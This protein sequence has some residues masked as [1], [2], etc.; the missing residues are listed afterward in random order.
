MRFSGLKLNIAVTVI[1]LLLTS[2]VLGNFVTVMF[3]KKSLVSSE[4][5]QA[6]SLSLIMGG[7][8]SGK[9]VSNGGLISKDL[10]RFINNSDNLISSVFF[11]GKK[12]VYIPENS[13]D[14]YMEQFVRNAG[15]LGEEQIKLDG[16]IWGLFSSQAPT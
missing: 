14:N 10:R 12:M 13:F 2:M 8:L 4:I 9:Q 1:L 16:N 5:K 3:W 11:D 6:Q 15:M 7:L